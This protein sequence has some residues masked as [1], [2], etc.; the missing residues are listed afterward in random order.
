MLGCCPACYVVCS[1]GLLAWPVRA[2]G[3]KEGNDEKV[4]AEDEATSPTWRD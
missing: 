3:E 4:K 2:G 1:A